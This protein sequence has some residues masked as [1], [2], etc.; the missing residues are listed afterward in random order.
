MTPRTLRF[1]EGNWRIILVEQKT[2]CDVVALKH[3]HF[4]AVMNEIQS[5]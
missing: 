5:H 1:G 3:F 2:F 4:P